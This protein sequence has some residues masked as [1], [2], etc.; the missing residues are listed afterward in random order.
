MSFKKF[1]KKIFITTLLVLIIGIAGILLLNNNK[2][3]PYIN[4]ISQKIIYS[5]YSAILKE[6]HNS[7]KN[8]IQFNEILLLKKYKKRLKEE[9]NFA[10]NI[11]YNIFEENINNPEVQYAKNKIIA[12]LRTLKFNEGGYFFIFDVNG[13]VVLNPA[14]PL[15]EGKN[16][17]KLKDINGNFYIKK[18][19]RLM[20]L[21]R[22]GYYEYLVKDPLKKNKTYRKIA[23]FKLFE[24][25]NWIIG[26]SE[27]YST[28]LNIVLKDVIDRIK[29]LNFSPEYG[30]ILKDNH[31]ILIKKNAP[32]KLQFLNNKT[33]YTVLKTFLPELQCTLISFFNKTKVS[34]EIYTLTNEIYNLIKILATIFILILIAI[35]LILLILFNKFGKN[36]ANDI[37]RFFKFFKKFP[38]VYSNINSEKLI[39]NEFKELANYANNMADTLKNLFEEMKKRD[40]FLEIITENSGIGITIINRDKKIEY[41]N[42]EFRTIINFENENFKEECFKL[43]KIKNCNGR[44]DIEDENCIISNI[45]IHK[46]PFISQTDSIITFDNREVPVFIIANPIIEN[47]IAK[48]VILIFRDISNERVIRNELLK[49]KRAI[50]QAPISIVITDTKGTIEFVNPFFCKI[51][52]Y[53]F[54]EAIGNNPKILKTKYNEK[55]HKDLWETILSGNIWTGEFLNK[56]KNKQL[57]WEKAVIAPIFDDQNKIINFVAIKQDV[58]E[59]KNLQKKLLKEKLK[60]ENANKVKSEFLASMSHE[61]RTPMNAI[62]G[63]IDLLYDTELTENQ[64]H[65]L[66]IIKSSS[67]NLLKILNDI[68]NLS[69][70]EAGKMEFESVNFNI[71]ELVSNCINIFSK[72]AGEKG[73]A[74]RYTIDDNI[75]Q[76]LKGDITRISQIINNLLSNAIK[77]TE[78]GEVGVNVKLKSKDKDFAELLFTVYDTGSG[79]PK[80]KLKSIFEAFTQADSSITRHY[81]GTGLGLTIISKIVQAYN[82]NIWAESEIG[83][84]SKFHFTLKLNIG[85]E[86]TTEKKELESD[87]NVNFYGS[88][89]LVAEDNITNQILIKE[90]LKRFNVESDMVENGLEA[91]KKLAYN[92]YNL[93]FFDW[94]MPIMDGVEAI[95]ILRKIENNEMIDDERVDAEILDKLKNKKFTVIALTAAVM[96][97]E[98]QVLSDVGFDEFLSKPIIKEELLKVLNRYLKVSKE[99]FIKE[100]ISALKE[101][102][103][104]N[105]ELMNTLLN[106]FRKTFNENILKIEK[107]LEAKDTES[108][109]F[110]AHSI[111]GTAYNIKLNLI[112]KI[113]EEIEN[114]IKENNFEKVKALVEKIKKVSV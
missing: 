44:C 43:F 75:P 89:V 74:L 111:K 78:K 105:E 34:N 45:F 109:R 25:Y 41:C 10:Y 106:S 22:K 12:I 16:I 67:K 18:I 8:F 69:K 84:G 91:L 4:N 13:N 7:I 19:I 61:I 47:N 42:S 40:E 104:D 96:N 114:S 83:K 70:L 52:G 97:E 77:F 54:E 88:K 11:S 20:L 113:A 63:F 53:S 39:L 93:I 102:I 103:G 81:G 85:D 55:F 56:K 94:H 82:G 28:I 99:S 21:K 72:K 68:L 87:L 95:K 9:V 112:G 5:K 27:N 6:Q 92:D 46:K 38:I 51:T 66:E 32:D 65:Y 33:D 57:Y 60:A 100:D 110:A 71:K 58:T 35:F 1:F 101:F 15:L 50:E 64:K 98:R 48:R 79:I 59:L 14:K 23:F 3:L 90:I 29:L 107:A 26:T 108:I 31:N 86:E 36:F 2:L 76:W 37:I 62:M 49:Y 17:L 24:P 73:L 80:E 30:F